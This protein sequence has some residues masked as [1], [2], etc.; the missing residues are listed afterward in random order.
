MQGSYRSK[1]LGAIG[2]LPASVARFRYDKTACQSHSLIG[3][4]TRSSDFAADT[5]NFPH[6]GRTSTSRSLQ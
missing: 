1:Q 3:L 4:G 2:T 6:E 5:E